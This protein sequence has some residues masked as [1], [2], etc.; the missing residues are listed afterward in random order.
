MAD[1]L[2][3][4]SGLPKGLCGV[5]FRHDGVAGRAALARAVLRCCRAR[6]LSMVAAGRPLGL[7]GVGAHLRGGR[8][9]GVCACPQ[10]RTASAHGVGDIVRARRMGAAAVFVSPVFATASHAGSAALGQVRWA[11]LARG[12]G[13]LALGG[14]D[15]RTV[16]GLPRWARGIGAIGALAGGV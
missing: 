3:V 2:G 1:V 15:G 9:A 4:V 5:V 7:A 11:A 14:I 12:G 10:Y 13:V 6:R 8:R 16:R